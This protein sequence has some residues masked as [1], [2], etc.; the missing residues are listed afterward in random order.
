[1]KPNGV[2]AASARQV[3]AAFSLFGLL[4]AG[5][6]LA[7]DRADI[8]LYGYSPDGRYFAFEEYGYQ[9]GSGFAYSNLHVIDLDADAWVKG[10]PFVS[11]TEDDSESVETVRA[12]GLADAAGSAL[13]RYDIGVSG[14]FIAMIGDGQ[15]SE[16]TSLSF[17]VPS[18]GGP[19][20]REG[21]YTLRLESFPADAAEPCPDYLDGDKAS[22]YALTLVEDGAPRELH[23]DVTIPKSRFCPRDYR[24]YGVVIPAG[25]TDLSRGVALISVYKLGFEGPDRRFLAVPLGA[26]P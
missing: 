3:A 16:G 23:R 11:Q 18:Y 24:L 1:M 22:G 6:V 13:D 26:K 5:P 7:G 2:R 9:D 14:T 19:N 4:A 15:Q 25:A 21:D 12:S 20:S 17:G 10:A 8:D